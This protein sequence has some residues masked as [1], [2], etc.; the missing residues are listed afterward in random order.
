MNLS[1]NNKITNLEIIVN[2][3]QISPINYLFKVASNLNSNK[4]YSAG[5]TLDFNLIKFCYPLQSSFNINDFSYIIP[6]NGIYQF[7]YNI[8]LNTSPTTANTRMAF[9][10]NGVKMMISGSYAS[11]IESCTTLEECN[12]SDLI[13]VRYHIGPNLTLFMSNDGCSFT[14]V[15]LKEI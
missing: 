15:L 12:E 6:K 13:T 14:G 3:T 1:L 10:K 4:V 7:S 8:Y 2:E 11:N 5:D 9:Y